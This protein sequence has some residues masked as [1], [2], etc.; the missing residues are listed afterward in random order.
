MSYLGRSG[1][2]AS[3][4]SDRG[5]DPVCYR[6][7]TM[8]HLWVMG[9]AFLLPYT[10]RMLDIRSCGGLPSCMWYMKQLHVCLFSY[11]GL[12]EKLSSSSPPSALQ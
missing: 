2:Y 1:I 10:A 5:R 9:L 12:V 11:S 8:V 6:L 7:H 3:S 4:G